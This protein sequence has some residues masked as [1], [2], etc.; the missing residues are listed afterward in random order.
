MLPATANEHLQSREHFE[1]SIFPP[2]CMIYASQVKSFYPAISQCSHILFVI[3]TYNSCKE[4]LT[5]GGDVDALG[6][7]YIKSLSYAAPTF[8]HE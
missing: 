8:R 2:C 6:I 7:R 1:S 4:S 5:Y 3:R